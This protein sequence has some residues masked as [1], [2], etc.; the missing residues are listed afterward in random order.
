MFNK[1]KYKLLIQRYMDIYD[2]S[3]TTAKQQ[4]FQLKPNFQPIFFFSQIF[5]QIK[6]C[7]QEMNVSYI[8]AALEYDV[9][10]NYNISI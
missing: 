1:T 7:M 10:N 8:Q 5:Q 6:E 2:V 4:I 3:Y 9:I